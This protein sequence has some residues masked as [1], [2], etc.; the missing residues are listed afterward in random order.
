MLL[1]VVSPLTSYNTLQNNKAEYKRKREDL[2]VVL[3]FLP[4]IVP[5][6]EKPPL[7]QRFLKQ[8]GEDS[9]GCELILT[10]DVPVN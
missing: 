4:R 8:F 6:G 7:D 10:R 3:I 1:L 2:S 9:E 5:L